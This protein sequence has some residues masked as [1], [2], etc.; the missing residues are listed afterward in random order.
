MNGATADAGGAS[1]EQA[2]GDAARLMWQN[3]ADL[4]TA[5]MRGMPGSGPGN[6]PGA[7]A[8][9]AAAGGMQA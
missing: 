1:S 9:S 2:F 4:A 7:A 3:W 6:G 8:Q 5:G